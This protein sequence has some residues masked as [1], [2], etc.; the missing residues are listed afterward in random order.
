[1]DVTRRW[2]A[3]HMPFPLN[4]FMPARMQGRRLEKL[5]LLRGDESLEAG[6]ELEKEVKIQSHCQKADK[7]STKGRM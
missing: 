4:F 5:R 3:E 7:L 2:Y 1:V 6:E